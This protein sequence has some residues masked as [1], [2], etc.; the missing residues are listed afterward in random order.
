[1]RVWMDWIFISR[2][3]SLN[4]YLNCRLTKYFFRFSNWNSGKKN[5]KPVHCILI[6]CVKQ[7]LSFYSPQECN[8]Q[9]SWDISCACWLPCWYIQITDWEDSHPADT[10]RSLQ[11]PLQSGIPVDV[12]QHAVHPEPGQ[13]PRAVQ[14]G[15]T[16]SGRE[17]PH[18]LSLGIPHGY[19]QPQTS[20]FAQQPAHIAASWGHHVHQ[21]PDLPGPLQQQS[22]D[23]AVGGAVH[24]AGSETSTR[25]R[26][27]QNDTW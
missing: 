24:L 4:L 12:F 16:T 17:C 10:E 21:E 8:L 1:M 26:K 2:P 18:R 19:A 9:W 27:L 14:P 7:K 11:L 22:P 3:N 13:F 15:R 5:S 20:W 23:P 25:P 6:F